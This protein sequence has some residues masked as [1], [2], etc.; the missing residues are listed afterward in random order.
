VWGWR[1][2]AA[3]AAVVVAATTALERVGTSTGLPFGEYRY[4]G[5]LEPTVAGVPLAVALA[6]LA[7]AVPAR[8]GWRRGSCARLAA[9]CSSA[10]SP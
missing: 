7:M 8:R 3:A 9:G 1:R 5:V 2:A 6:W 10:P 4:T